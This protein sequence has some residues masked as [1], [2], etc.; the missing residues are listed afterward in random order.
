MRFV[1]EDLTN[2]KNFISCNDINTSG[3]PRYHPS[4]L[5]QTALNKIKHT[6]FKLR[7]FFLP[8]RY[9]ISTGVAHHPKDWT[10]DFNLSTN[11]FASL[12][13]TYI[14]DLQLGR[15]LL[16]L[17]QSLE[18]YQ[19]DWLWQ[20]LHK[21]CQIYDVNPRA[22]IYVTGNLLAEEQYMIWANEN[23]INVI[24]I[25]PYAHFER[26]IGLLAQQL[27][28]NPDKEEEF[29]YKKSNPI[30]LYNCL[31]K[32]LRVHRIWFYTYLVRAGLID[33]GLISMNKFNSTGRYFENR[34]LEV[35]TIEQA[36]ALLPSTIYGKNN[37][38]QP[39]SYYI[40]RIRNDVCKDSWISI[41]TESSFSDLDTEIFISEKTFKPIAC[42]HPFIIVGN[43]GS[44]KQLRS[45]G[46]RTFDGFIDESYDDLPTFERFE[47]IIT[48]LQKI[49]NIKDKLS[50]YKSMQDILEHNYKQ[51]SINTAKDNPALTKLENYYNEYFR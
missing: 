46:Y 47:A 48:A 39:D 22:L 19:T 20:H 26:D 44:L 17:D 2:K 31:N 33:Q 23:N 14:K 11:I 21:E 7:S 24:M 50:W 5:A 28:L 45:M 15:A 9:I 41:V 3:L 25:I 27:K 4:P 30:K 37:T 6:K 10:G 13:P 16:L 42:K 18:G 12:N 32:R 35:S 1:F 49:N 36:D 38:E 51:L 34:M 29:K 43:Q 8:S 40:N